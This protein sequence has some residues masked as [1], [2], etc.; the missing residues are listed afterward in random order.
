MAQAF[1]QLATTKK[2]SNK[3]ASI[4]VVVKAW[5][6]WNETSKLYIIIFLGFLTS[7]GRKPRMVLIP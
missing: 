2:G 5:M 4:V 3:I 7:T 6:F 1:Y